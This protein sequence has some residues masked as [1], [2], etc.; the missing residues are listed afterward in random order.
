MVIAMLKYTHLGH[1]SSFT[2]I[3]CMLSNLDIK[4]FIEICSMDLRDSGKGS[5]LKF[6]YLVM[7]GLTL[8]LEILIDL[9]RSRS[10][11]STSKLLVRTYDDVR[12]KKSF[13]AMRSAG[14][15]K[16]SIGDLVTSVKV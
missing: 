1:L 6:G 4:L 11:F 16:I 5:L 8:M 14:T 10:L 9:N 13:D 2:T 15:V 3:G 7:S 12:V